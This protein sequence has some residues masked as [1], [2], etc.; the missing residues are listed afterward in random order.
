MKLKYLVSIIA[1]TSVSAFGAS[2][3]VTN[4]AGPVNTQS[5]VDNTGAAVDGGF[6]AIGSIS[7]VSALNTLTSAGL[8]A[9]FT[10]YDGA[11]GAVNNAPF[12]G[13]YSISNN[14]SDITGTAWAGAP[15]YLVLGNGGD[16]ASST[17]G[18]VLRVGN[19]PGSEPAVQTVN[20]NNTAEVLLGS[21]DTFTLQ[22]GP[23]PTQNAALALA[24][25]V[26]EPS[27]SLLIG[28][29]GLSLLIRRRR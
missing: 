18:A 12:N 24:P 17:Q 10:V 6:A 26:P 7:D 23:I 21:F 4:N 29:A 15:I 11:T 13:T 16:L 14:G 9:L 8:D 28:L 1:L 20:V 5:V 27:S 2:V 19:F 25:F 3:T 22:P